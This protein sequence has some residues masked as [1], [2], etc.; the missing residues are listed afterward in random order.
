MHADRRHIGRLDVLGLDDRRRDRWNITPEGKR[1][2]W[3]IGQV[4]L[5]DSGPDGNINSDDNTLFAV[6]GV[7]IPYSTGGSHEKRGRRLF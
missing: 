4:Q 5:W 3:A 6:Q 1:S 2:T 7:F